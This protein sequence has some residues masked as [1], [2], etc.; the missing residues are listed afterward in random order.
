MGLGKE[1]G[2]GQG[3][4]SGYQHKHKH[5]AENYSLFE[6]TT[7]WK[8]LNWTLHVHLPHH[9]LSLLQYSWSP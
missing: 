3:V 2:I 6:N 9:I 7:K 8:I 1:N 5:R 4:K